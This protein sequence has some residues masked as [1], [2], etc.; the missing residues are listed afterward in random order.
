VEIMFLI[1]RL[2]IRYSNIWKAYQDH[3]RRNSSYKIQTRLDHSQA[4]D[5]YEQGSDV[6][7][8]TL[9][10]QQA[11]VSAGP[12]LPDSHS[13]HLRQERYQGSRNIVS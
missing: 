5:A 4:S 7:K 9:G 6:Y 10:N 11:A 13:M 12:E 3:D 1:V 2:L 8:A